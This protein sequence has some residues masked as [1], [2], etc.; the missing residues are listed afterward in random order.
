MK[1]VL[2]LFLMFFSYTFL[3]A[4]KVYFIYLQSE[5]S[6]PFYIKIGD[7]VVSST[8]E[9]YLI[10]PKLKDSTYTFSVGFSGKQGE[11]KF[12]VS[13]NKTDRGFLIKN[14][15][16]VLSLFDLQSLVIYNPVQ[17]PVSTTQT[18]TKTDSFTKLLSKAADDST[19]LTESLVVR[20]E[21]KP[22]I[23]EANSKVEKP[24][25]TKEPAKP[26][27]AISG[28]AQIAVE[29]S[30][31]TSTSPVSQKDTI[32][33]K[34]ISTPASILPEVSVKQ[35]TKNEP[36]EAEYIKSVVLKHA[37]SSTSDGFGLVFLDVYQGLIDTVRIIIPNPQV[38]IE[39]P[40]K[41][42]AEIKPSVQENKVFLEMG[43][44]TSTLNKDVVERELPEV[45]KQ[46][47]NCLA[48]ASDDDFF[49]MRKDIAS[50][51]TEED[52]LAQ[53]RKHFKSRCFKTEHIKYLSVLFLTDE[54]K[55]KFFDTAYMHVSDLQKFDS[56]QSEITEAYYVNRFK[57]LIGK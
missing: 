50:K 22:A 55:Y 32:A 6:L 16:E 48:I 33:Q 54:G 13:I 56:L 52:M 51:K 42:S 43:D 30:L 1:K 31:E 40:A 12:T 38:I 28:I 17:A 4:Q 24:E 18:A 53:A 19:L 46:K 9:G 36:L 27:V 15:N 37:E 44:T 20:E 14:F 39:E 21:K 23:I 49:K 34:K 47:S 2:L 5:T 11:P 7:K 41:V 3:Y 29:P 45:K 57:A 8:T 35:E 25:E 10:L 26:D